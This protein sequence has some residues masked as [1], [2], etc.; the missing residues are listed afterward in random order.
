[1]VN[2]NLNLSII[3]ITHGKINGRATVNL[4]ISILDSRTM[5]KNLDT[6]EPHFSKQIE[7]VSWPFII[8]RFHCVQVYSGILPFADEILMFPILIKV[9][10][11]MINS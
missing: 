1:M 7:P 5:K 9:L 11:L 2:V 10:K 3:I 6:T 4:K 8:L